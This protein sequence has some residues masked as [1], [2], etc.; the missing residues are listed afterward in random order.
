MT[1]E[2]YVRAVDQF[3]ELGH[4]DKIRHFAWYLDRHRNQARF[5]TS[6][7]TSCFDELHLHRPKN[8][9][10]MVLSLVGR[11]LIRDS[12]GFRVA[13]VLRDAFDERLVVRDE[14]VAVDAL[15]SDLP[16]QLSDPGQEDYLQEAIVCFRSKA[17][18][19][20]VIMTWN[21]AYDHLVTVVVRSHLS[22]FNVQLTGM[23]GG[24]KKS[25]STK[26]DFQ[27]LRESEVLE[28][29]GAAGI[30]S[31]EVRKVL[32]GALGKRNSAAHPSGT[33]VDKLQAEA[34]VSDVINNAMLKIK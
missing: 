12:D 14:T 18:R 2:Q 29:C 30:V 28:V 10:Q 20:A 27:R 31:K 34:F 33:K 26:D 11:D 23:F 4:T 13:K 15:L 21:V 1:L 16:T 6:D 5:R 8:A 32:D 19:A 25:V 17:F 9:S 3:D 7:I 24:R 22:P